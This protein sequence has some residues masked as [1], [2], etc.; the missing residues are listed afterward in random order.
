[1]AVEYRGETSQPQ[2]G[3]GGGDLVQDHNIRLEDH[4]DVESDVNHP[5]AGTQR[6]APAHDVP[7]QPVSQA[8]DLAVPG[9]CLSEAVGPVVV[10]RHD[11]SLV[12]LDLEGVPSDVVLP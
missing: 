2:Q 9:D 6:L 4:H 5:D 11:D 1:M 10:G 7:G 12:V 3:Q 8:D